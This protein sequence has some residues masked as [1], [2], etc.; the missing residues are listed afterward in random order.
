MVN[1]ILSDLS[2]QFIFPREGKT[3]KK[4]IY[5]PTTDEFLNL[6][7]EEIVSK[8]LKDAISKAKDLGIEPTEKDWNEI[9][10]PLRFDE[11]LNLEESSSFG[12]NTDQIEQEIDEGFFLQ[13]GTDDLEIHSISENEPESQAESSNRME[14][15]ELRDYSRK[16]KKCR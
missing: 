3:L 7:I 5:F 9:H 1:S 6:D 8:S 13:D 10:I 2:G 16:I 15:L 12:D 11:C 4:N 14:K